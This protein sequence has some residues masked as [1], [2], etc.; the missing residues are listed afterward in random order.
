MHSSPIKYNDLTEHVQLT[1]HQFL[2]SR[3]HQF[4][5]HAGGF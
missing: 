1:A 5:G 4:L 2:G 3:I